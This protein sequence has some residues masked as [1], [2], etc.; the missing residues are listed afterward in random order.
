MFPSIRPRYR[1][2]TLT[3]LL[4]TTY[5]L[6]SKIHHLTHSH[7][8]D[9]SYNTLFTRQFNVYILT[10]SC[11]RF[12]P[13][14]VSQFDFNES[15]SS[16]YLVPN[17]PGIPECDALGHQQ[18]DI[19][20]NTETQSKDDLFRNKYTQVLTHCHTSHKSK[21]LILEDDII[22]LHPGER[23][24]SVLIENTLPLF[25]DGESDAFDCTKRGF[26]WFG[27][28]H[29]GMG[30]QCRVYSAHSAECLKSCL[31]GPEKEW[32]VDTG[33]RNCQMRCGLKQK[34]FLLVVHGGLGSTMGRGEKE[35]KGIESEG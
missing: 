15:S 34:R 13:D 32:Q 9:L 29:T 17:G 26:G 16:I 23:T 31:E 4:A 14:I 35:N 1:Y 25:N 20:L 28:T 30:S 10:S 7:L 22:F 19:Y 18:L 3:L 11:D 24:R 21:C 33:L 5:L 12:T 8:Y 27:T 6:S 2:L